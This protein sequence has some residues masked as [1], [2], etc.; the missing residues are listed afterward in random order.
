VSTAKSIL[1]LR[2]LYDDA[3]AWS[4]RAQ[5]REIVFQESLEQVR[6]STTLSVLITDLHLLALWYGSAAIQ[7]SLTGG[8]VDGCLST[9]H[10]AAILEI[11]GAVQSFEADT[12][13]RRQF[14]LWRSATS[15]HGCRAFA[16]GWIADARRIAR[17]L[18]AE[19][20]LGLISD[21]SHLMEVFFKAILGRW[22]G[23][24]L[25]A[26][27]V[28][29]PISYGRLLNQW[30][31]RGVELS[32][33]LDAACEERLALAE[34]DDQ[35]APGGELGDHFYAV[36]PAELLA[37]QRL[38]TLRGLDPIPAQHPLMTM[39]LGSLRDVSRREPLEPTLAALAA[40]VAQGRAPSEA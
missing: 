31:G 19:P 20:E 16:G 6:A 35:L 37:L 4:S 23:S 17:L 15:L 27:V 13:R 12:R 2:A 34:N 3:V 40:Q 11:E 5:N 32:P 14:R 29:L 24:A 28:G 36:F 7:E 18:R 33:I 8:D 21:G 25:G 22:E 9:A 30:D 1:K 39:P 26:E 38:R 10:C